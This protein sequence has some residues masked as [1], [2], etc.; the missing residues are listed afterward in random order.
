MVFSRRSRFV[1]VHR[2]Q[3]SACASNN[4]QFALW[5]SQL[6]WWQCYWHSQYLT[7]TMQLSSFFLRQN[8]YPLRW[9]R[10]RSFGNCCDESR[11]AVSR[12]LQFD[13]L[14]TQRLRSRHQIDFKLSKRTFRL[15]RD[16]SRISANVIRSFVVEISMYMKSKLI[17]DLDCDVLA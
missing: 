15:F 16:V 3:T 12:K 11:L 17:V 6:F 9:R 2:V 13:H 10:P 7:T 8:Q 4:S 1:G 14:A 5:C